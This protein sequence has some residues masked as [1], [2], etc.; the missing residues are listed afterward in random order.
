MTIVFAFDAALLIDIR[1]GTQR[2]FFNFIRN[3]ARVQDGGLKAVSSV[4]WLVNSGRHALDLRHFVIESVLNVT[5]L[6]ARFVIVFVVTGVS[7]L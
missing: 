3:F 7:K 1:Y 6:S 2:S 4:T 5:V